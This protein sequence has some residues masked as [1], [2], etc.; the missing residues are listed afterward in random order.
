MSKRYC[1]ALAFKRTN[2]RGP[3]NFPKVGMVEAAGEATWAAAPRFAAH[4]RGGP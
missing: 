4:E 2:S 1:R 3:C